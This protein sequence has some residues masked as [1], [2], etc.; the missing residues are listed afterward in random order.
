MPTFKTLWDMFPEAGTLKARCQNKQKDISKPFDDYCAILL[1]ECFIR[2]GVGLSSA[3]RDQFCWSHGAP[4]HIL[5]AENLAKWLDTHPV[6]D[7][8]R[9]E[10]RISPSN[11]QDELSGRTGVIFFKDYWR[12]GNENFASRSGDHIDLWN[13]NEIT[14]SSMLRRAVAE[15]FGLVSDLNDSKE[16]WFWEVK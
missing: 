10:K 9:T 12:R 11:F 3:P 16:V 5:L 4:H 1:S 7:F 6:P 2:S 14:S 15:F 13:N 8:G